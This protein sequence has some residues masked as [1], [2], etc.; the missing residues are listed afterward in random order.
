[1]VLS[2]L[3]AVITLV[4]ERG[5]WAQR[6]LIGRAAQAFESR[7]PLWEVLAIALVGCTVEFVIFRLGVRLWLYWNRIRRTRL[8]WALTHALLSIAGLAA[9]LLTALMLSLQ[10]MTRGFSSTLTFNVIPILFFLAF[11]TALGL[12]VVLPPSALFSYLFARHVTQRL[13]ALAKATSALRAGDY[14]IRVPVTGEDEV[15]QLQSNFNAMAADLDRA[16]S[17]VHAERDN[18]AALLR[19]RRELVASVSHELRTP[20]ATLRGYLESTLTH[21]N[22]SPPPTLRRDLEV[23]ERETV[24]LQTLIN[25][26]FTLA[27]AE[28]GHLELR[29]APTDVDALA[30]HVVETMAPLA[31][32]SGRV[33]VVAEVAPNVPLAQV[34]GSRLEQVLQNLLHN[35]VRHTPPG[36]IVAVNVRAEVEAVVLQVQDTGEGIA[37]EELS[38]IWERFYRAGKARARSDGGSGLGLALV[39]ELT[40]AMGGTVAAESVT[41]EGSSFTVRVPRA[42]ASAPTTGASLAQRDERASPLAGVRP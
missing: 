39:K 16:V 35:A 23:M 40:E 25:D 42:P 37:A 27:R 15:A 13:Q 6:G 17:E 30:H 33:E 36:G 11:L 7:I 9:G 29:M 21:W 12:A 20:V 8:R 38:R 14:R 4:T 24:R 10:V 19:A 22:G 18:V 5:A 1:V 32:Q 3:P 28:V 41:G 26:L 34:D 2:V 31:W